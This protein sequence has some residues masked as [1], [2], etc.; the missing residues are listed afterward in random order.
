MKRQE[1][2]SLQTTLS[3]I[4][5]HSTAKK[6]DIDELKHKLAEGIRQNRFKNESLANK[7]NGYKKNRSKS[8][9]PGH[10]MMSDEFPEKGSAVKQYS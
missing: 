3:H 9:S 4:I 8:K 5:Q 7:E 1:I 6:I 10:F 2:E